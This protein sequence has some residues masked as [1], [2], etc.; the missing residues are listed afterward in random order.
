[1]DGK[2]R[3]TLRI[4]KELNNSLTEKAEKIG[5]SKNGLILQILWRKVEEVTGNE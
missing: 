1:M 4:P 2:S 5:I 3:L